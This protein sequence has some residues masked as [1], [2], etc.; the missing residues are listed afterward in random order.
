MDAAFSEALDVTGPLAM[1]AYTDNRSAIMSTF[2]SPY[3][4]SQSQNDLIVAERIYISSLK[5]AKCPTNVLHFMGLIIC[6]CQLYWL[7]AVVNMKMFLGLFTTILNYHNNTHTQVV[8][9]IR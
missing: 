9:A 2:S 3:L 7:V 5:G 8:L 4:D 1:L 6:I